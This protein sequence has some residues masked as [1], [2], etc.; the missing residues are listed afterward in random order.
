MRPS[1]TASPF[2]YRLRVHESFGLGA[3]RSIEERHGFAG[4]VRALG[5]MGGH[6]GAPHQKGPDARRRP[7]AA[8]EAYSLYVE[9]A[10]KGANEADGP[11]SAACYFAGTGSMAS[12][13]RTK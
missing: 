6:V 13:T 11:F 7:P 4:A 2:D 3:C 1:P 9:R 10:A 12:R 5:G 8:R